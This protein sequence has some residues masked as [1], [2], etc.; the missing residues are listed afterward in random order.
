[1]IKYKSPDNKGRIWVVLDGRVTG[2]IEPVTTITGYRYRPKG[3]KETGDTFDS[4]AQ[5]KRSIE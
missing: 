5:V 1:M 2:W 4:I 3:E